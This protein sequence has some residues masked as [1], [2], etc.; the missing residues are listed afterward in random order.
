MEEKYSVYCA[1]CGKQLSENERPCSRCGEEK[2]NHYLE[3]T[4]SITPVDNLY[5]IQQKNPDVPGD[6]YEITHKTKIS[7]KTKRPTDETM[8]IDRTN[9][10]KTIKNHLIREWDGEKWITCHDELNESDAKHRKKTNNG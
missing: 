9:P 8:I 5:R 10:E 3:L 2:R 6:I 1:K 7:G 4:D